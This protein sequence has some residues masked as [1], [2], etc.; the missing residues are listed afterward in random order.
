MVLVWNRLLLLLLWQILFVSMLWDPIHQGWYQVALSECQGWIKW[1]YKLKRSPWLIHFAKFKW[2]KHP[3][4]TRYHQTLQDWKLHKQRH[5]KNNFFSTR[6]RRFVTNIYLT[7]MCCSFAFCQRTIIIGK[8]S[9]VPRGAMKWSR[10]LRDTSSSSW[11]TTIRI[12]PIVFKRQYRH[13]STYIHSCIHRLGCEFV[14]S[15]C[16]LI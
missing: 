6:I 1:H 16:L 4:T 12:A 15:W 8:K 14:M 5:W 7:V 9:S 2:Q 11:R 10:G 3:R 13:T